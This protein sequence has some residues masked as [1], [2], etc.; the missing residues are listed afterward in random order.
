MVLEK[1]NSR[2]I[3][4]TI[5]NKSN[6]EYLNC[7]TNTGL[8]KKNNEDFAVTIASP[9]ND[10]IKLLIVCD[11]LGGCDNG[12]KASE[13]VCDKLVNW[14][15]NFDFNS[16]LSINIQKIMTKQIRKI[17]YELKSCIKGGQT[18][19]T[20]ALVLENQT[21]IA[22][23]GDSRTYKIKDDEL[24]QLTKDDSEIWKFLYR[25]GK[26]RYTKDELRF[27]RINNLVSKCLGSGF[28]LKINTD[29]IDN[30]LYD[31]LL[32]MSDGI[33]DIVSDKRIKELLDENDYNDF[34]ISLI[35]EAN[36]SES[37]FFDGM[38]ESIFKSPTIPGKDNET[39]ALYLKLKK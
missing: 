3:K 16:D 24:V 32:L 28:C 18:T 34:L 38:K 39:A 11:G 21:V 5:F 15:N 7:V 22:N 29:I 9:S 30:N 4:G 31:G 8:L 37:E 2:L 14:F 10:K 26:G 12:D 13:F 6:L 27:F 36:Y 17:N 33:T 23:I 1:E 25:N 35:N 20:M 19:L